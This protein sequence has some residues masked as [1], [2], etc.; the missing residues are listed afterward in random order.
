[1]TGFILGV[2]LGVVVAFGI[3]GL[4][5]AADDDPPRWL[6]PPDDDDGVSRLEDDPDGQYSR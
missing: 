3:A 1:M 6:H 4:M 2:I 5:A